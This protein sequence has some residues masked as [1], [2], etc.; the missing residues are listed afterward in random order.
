MKM[1]WFRFYHEALFD[2]KIQSLPGDAFKTWANILCVASL[3]K[4]RG[5][6]PPIPDVAFHLHLSLDAAQAV[7]DDLLVRGLLDITDEG[8]MPHNWNER[9]YDRTPGAKRQK[10]YRDRLAGGARRDAKPPTRVIRDVTRDAS[11]DVTRYVSRDG[12]VTPGVTSQITG[13]TERTSYGGEVGGPVAAEGSD[14]LGSMKS[15][16]APETAPSPEPA[17]LAVVS[18]DGPVPEGDPQFDHRDAIAQARVSLGNDAAKRIG[19]NPSAIA[20]QIH[21]RWDCLV[22]SIRRV[23]EDMQPP[24]NKIFTSPI[25]YAITLA[26]SWAVDGIPEPAPASHKRRNH[27]DGGTANPTNRLIAPGREHLFAGRKENVG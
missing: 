6:L 14:S 20:K 19:R 18:A 2:P 5:V 15:E 13:D 23:A 22:A 3:Q 8:L 4:E 26:A 9:Q 24:T 11:G 1:A 7:I 25:G 27:S 17:R 10:E 21:G 12:T 16:T